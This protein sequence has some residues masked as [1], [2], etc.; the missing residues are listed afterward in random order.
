MG[1]AGST[2][3][4]C[5]QPVQGLLAVHTGVVGSTDRDCGQVAGTGAVGRQRVQGLWAAQPASS[6]DVSPLKGSWPARCAEESLSRSESQRRLSISLQPSFP[7]SLIDIGPPV[8]TADPS[9]SLCLCLSVSL[10]LSLSLCVS[11][12]LSVCLS[13][14][15]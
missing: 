15:L 11:V 14:T 9:L 10:S 3:R 13:V 1:V 2:D 6:V 7:H 5:G 8:S 4:G 12:C